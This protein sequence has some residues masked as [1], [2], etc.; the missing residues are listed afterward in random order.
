MLGC[1][2]CAASLKHLHWLSKVFLI[3]EKNRRKICLFVHNS[4]YIYIYKRIYTRICIYIRIY[5]MCVYAGWGHLRKSRTAKMFTK[6]RWH[7]FTSQIKLAMYIVI[8][9]FN[10]IARFSISFFFFHFCMFFNQ[11]KNKC[12]LITMLISSSLSFFHPTEMFQ[13]KK[14][15]SDVYA[16][17]LAEAIVH[18][19]VKR[20]YAG[21]FGPPPISRLAERTLSLSLLS[22]C[23]ILHTSHNWSTTVSA[24]HIRCFSTCFLHRL[25]Y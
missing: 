3:S 20:V 19:D 1:L 22:T 4:T 10:W 21:V 16:L 12:P 25:L 18:L 24:N 23:E 5:I 2:F 7:V 14:C 9:S 15:T 17:E 8:V 6:T 13:S 11:K